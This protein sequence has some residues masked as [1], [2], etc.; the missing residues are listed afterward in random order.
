MF[1]F[2]EK[3]KFVDFHPKTIHQNKT[4]KQNLKIE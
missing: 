3:L 2:Q 4:P 1:I